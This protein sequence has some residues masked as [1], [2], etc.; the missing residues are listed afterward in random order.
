MSGKTIYVR[1]MDEGTEVFRPAP[2]VQLS[3]RVFRLL[4]SEGY[5][6]EDEKWEFL[7]GSNVVLEEKHLSEGSLLVAKA[8]ADI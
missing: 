6:P 8:I 4:E 3:D 1:L 2:A 5:D 7:P